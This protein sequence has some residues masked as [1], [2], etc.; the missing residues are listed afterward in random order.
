M[1]RNRVGGVVVVDG[2]ISSNGVV[3]MLS[4]VIFVVV[5]VAVFVFNNHSIS[6]AALYESFAWYWHPPFL[7]MKSQYCYYKFKHML[8]CCTLMSLVFNKDK[9]K[10]KKPPAY[11]CST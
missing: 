2:A 3:Q 10:I 4:M 1:S 6:S 11:F 7:S 8:P 5:L 9:I